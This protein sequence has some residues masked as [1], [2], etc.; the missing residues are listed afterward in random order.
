MDRADAEAIIRQMRDVVIP[1]EGI[2]LQGPRPR[3]LVETTDGTVFIVYW[4]PQ[5]SSV[6]DLVHVSRGQMS[7]E[8][9]YQLRLHPVYYAQVATPD[10]E[11]SMVRIAAR[12]LLD[13]LGWRVVLHAV[14]PHADPIPHHDLVGDD[15]PPPP[16]IPTEPTWS[17]TVRRRNGNVF[18]FGA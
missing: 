9:E 18:H 17:Y 6:R 1:D 2:P 5:A 13:T 14:V 7:E 15:I 4:R 8:I 10:K 3:G 16:P 12:V 11:A